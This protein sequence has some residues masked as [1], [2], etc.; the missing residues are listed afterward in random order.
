M[1]IQ[2]STSSVDDTSS[3][4]VDESAEEPSGYLEGEGK[5]EEGQGRFHHAVKPPLKHERNGHSVTFVVNN[6]L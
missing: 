4:L 6:F 3:M 5:E 2:V 1:A